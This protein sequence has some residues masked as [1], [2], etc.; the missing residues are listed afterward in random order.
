MRIETGAGLVV[1]GASLAGLR[2]VEAARKSGF[3]GPI[4][5]IGAEDHLPYDRPPLSKQFLDEGADRVDTTA[6]RTDEHLRK[7]LAVELVLGQPA[8]GLDPSAHVVAVGDRSIPYDSIVIATGATARM[9]P[10]CEGVAGIH[11]LRTI[12]DAVAIRD[13]LDAG[14]R[15]VV[16]G[17]GFI[18]SE[19][20]SAAAKRGGRV[21]VVEMADT[22]L[23]RSVGIEIGPVFARLHR[24]HGTDLRLG[25]GVSGITSE[26][27]THTVTLT[28]GSR[29][30]TDLVVVGIGASPATD[31]LESS[32]IELHGRDRS[33][34]ADKH[35]R[36]NAPD[37]YAAGDVVTW[38]NPLFGDPMRLEHWTSAAEQAAVAARN[39]LGRK[40]PE[41]YETVPYFWSDWYGLRIQFAGVHGADEVRVVTRMEDEGKLLALYR[42]GDLLVGALTIA[43]P[44]LIMKFRRKIAHRTSWNEALE[45]AGVP[46]TGMSTPA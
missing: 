29:L 30:D 22:P 28:D 34:V 31:W 8:T 40:P 14:A 3:Q 39:A 26:A 13:A 17:S 38:M 20:A 7:E 19:I 11:A 1:V 32:G 5:L 4:T 45:F 16:I 2:A 41:A 44:S 18:G 33:I 24:D 21:V 6:F 15:T 35:L 36:T 27:G 12:D 42:R 23:Q 9:M 46:L 25:V 10:G 43:Q 37:V